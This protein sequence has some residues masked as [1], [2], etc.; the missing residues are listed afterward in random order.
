MTRQQVILAVPEANLL[1]LME[2]AW[3]IMHM[4]STHPPLPG[5]SVQ[6]QRLVPYSTLG[7]SDP[8]PEGYITW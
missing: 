6:Q 2:H 7:G 4:Q 5:L 3:C 8:S 1:M